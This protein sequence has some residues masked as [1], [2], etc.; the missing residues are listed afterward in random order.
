[1]PNPDG[2]THFSTWEDA[3]EKVE[4][5]ADSLES[6]VS[7]TLENDGTFKFFGNGRKV[8]TWMCSDKE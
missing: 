4:A 2:K 8:A 7:I 6:D 1:M 5:F 3:L